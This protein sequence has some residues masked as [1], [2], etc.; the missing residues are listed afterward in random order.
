MSRM[1]ME[2]KYRQT[3][4]AVLTAVVITMVG[5][6]AAAPVDINQYDGAIKA[7]DLF[8]VDCLLPGQVRQ[9]GQNYTYI[10]PRRPIRSSA[11]DCSKRGGEYV[12]Y[13]RASNETALKVWLPDA[14]RGDANAQTHVGEIYESG[15]GVEPDYHQ[16]VFWYQKAAA[17]GDSRAMIN[18]GTLY[19]A[20][21]GV[22]R[23]MTVAMNWYRQASGIEQGNLEYTTDEQLAQ[24]RAL[25]REAEELRAQV[26]QLSDELAAANKNM[27]RRKRDLRRAQDELS[28]TVVELEAERAAAGELSAEDREALAGMRRENE[29]LKAQLGAARTEQSRVKFEFNRTRE[30]AESAELELSQT[31][32]A[33]KQLKAD[34]EAAK[35][36]DR[37]QF[38]GLESDLQRQLEAAKE[39]LDQAQE[40][41][42]S[43]QARLESRDQAIT[44][45]RNSLTQTQ[46]ELKEAQRNLSDSDETLDLLVELEA[47]IADK[48]A[49]IQ[50]F[51]ATT[52]ELLDQL[53]GDSVYAVNNNTDNKANVISMISPEVVV[54]RGVRSVTLFS[55]LNDYEL[56]GQV[57]AGSELLGFKVNDRDLLDTIDQ[58]GLF[59]VR[60]P[61]A[62]DGDTPV[63]IEAV[64][65]DGSKSQESFL[66]QKNLPAP[67]AV[68]ETSMQFQGRLRSDLGNFYALVIGNNQYNHH[69]RL[70]TAVND[71][72]GVA[73]A[74]RKHYGYQV[75][76]MTNTSREQLV[77]A[78]A[79]MTA[80]LTKNDN[81]LIY[82]AGHGVVDDDGQGY[83]LPVDASAERDKSWVG[84]AQLSGFI[85]E[86]KAKH[87]L[88]V[89][90]S[91]YSGT[92]SG[93]SIR[94]IPLAIADE[95]LL[96]I[97]RVR[98][99]TVLT[100]G[101]LQPVIDQGGDGHSIFGGAFIRALSSNRNL[102]EGYRLFESVRQEVS[103]RSRLARVQ[104]NPEYTA[105]KFAG[106]EG[107]EF[108][109]L[110]D[111]TRLGQI[112]VR[113]LLLAP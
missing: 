58:N 86:M 84:N 29:A 34:R 100:S 63:S 46:A 73:E 91:C 76:L 50:E 36:R 54:T 8:I 112:G 78:L 27:A 53:V 66:I 99:R 43:L 3:G 94:P 48:E 45:I 97:S 68:R 20:G 82:Y 74:L 41:E 79:A 49:Q 16:A 15:L 57:T 83:W 89:A 70:S 106:H 52:A 111:P 71:A 109:F 44:R 10:A 32:L 7:D 33:L 88:V 61:I 59:K 38:D 108:F 60:V 101:G 102:M 81:L 69:E 39:R 62:T 21:R 87:V 2:N 28:R 107:S 11:R 75:T 18:L 30:L 26:V 113:Q 77:K 13:D 110:P 4:L 80:Q 104:Q 23:D 14:D 6:G 72:E 56:I 22:E 17:Q 92:L 64:L 51:E 12:A 9:L 42:T 65:N 35:R 90:D 105:L 93:T 40:R 96:F 1:K 19:E 25:A 67:V 47:E 103:G 24:R 85:A 95:D 98:A 55:D 5:L 37:S 31:R